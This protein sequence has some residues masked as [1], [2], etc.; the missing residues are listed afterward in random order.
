MALAMGISSYIIGFVISWKLS[1][2]MFSFVPFIIASGILMVY[3][4]RNASNMDSKAYESAGAI[5][6]ETINNI[7]TIASF[8][9]FD[10]E[11]SRYKENSEKSLKSGL[12]VGL[13]NGMTMGFLYF[14]IFVSYSL[15]IW[16]GGKLI[17][18]DIENN[19]SNS[20]INVGDIIIVLETVVFGSICLGQAA[21]NLTAI[22]Q[23]CTEAYEFFELKKR[24]P[25][26]DLSNSTK[27]PSKEKLVGTIE[28]KNVSFTY[29]KTP[30][31][32]L[33]DDLNLTIDPNKITA[34]VGPSGSGKT[35]IVSLIERLYD[36]DSGQ[37]L[38]DSFNVKELDI[39]YFR[40][41][42]GL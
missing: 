42:I 25:L 3:F 32:K 15:A 2:V 37:V 10:F 4:M 19:N 35:T 31:V 40:S 11:I 5:A 36:V 18:D 14:L 38:I 27:K 22:T 21:P 13:Y 33:F 24:K 6:E 41:L 20:S 1:L 26:I 12:K 39:K 30:N 23:A 8:S 29:P 7:K 16:Y 9:Q 34:V 28:F 17:V